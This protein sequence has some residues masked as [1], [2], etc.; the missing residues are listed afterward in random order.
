MPSLQT[1]LTCRAIEENLRWV[2]ERIGDLK[3]PENFEVVAPIHD[4]QDPPPSRK[5]RNLPLILPLCVSL[6]R[7]LGWY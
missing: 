4:A 6:G 2:R 7:S 5:Q 1:E 3:I